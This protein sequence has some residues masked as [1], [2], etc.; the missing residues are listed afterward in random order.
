ME[1]VYDILKPIGKAIWNGFLYTWERIKPFF[2]FIAFLIRHLFEFQNISINHIAYGIL[3]LFAAIA[4]T[5]QDCFGNLFEKMVNEEDYGIKGQPVIKE[6]LQWFAVLTLLLHQAFIYQSL[7]EMEHNPRRW[8]NNYK[9]WFGTK[10]EWLLRFLVLSLLLIGVGK[11]EIIKTLMKHIKN[12]LYPQQ[13]LIMIASFTLFLVL[14]L[15]NT[16]AGFKCKKW[17]YWWSDFLAL[18][19]WLG[20]TINANP[21]FFPAF[22]SFLIFLVA[23]VL[24]YAWVIFKRLYKYLQSIPNSLNTN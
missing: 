6:I 3:W 11:V 24:F 15:W 5:S 16:V 21:G 2:N 14:T 23:I 17:D 19:F 7:H 13:N 4:L 9:G 20:I 22:D 10:I 18:I 1:K 8:K 12:D